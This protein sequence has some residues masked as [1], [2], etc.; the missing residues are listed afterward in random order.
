MT[1]KNVTRNALFTSIISLLLC[2]SMLVGTTFAWFTDSVVSGVNTIAAGNLDVELYHSDKN[3]SGYV[4]A[5]T[6]LFNDVEKWEPG[7]VVF[8]NFKVENVGNLALK[9]NLSI[10]FEN[11]TKVVDA[12]G[13]EHGLSE[14][15][16]V[17]VVEGGFTGGR[18]EAQNIVFDKSLATFALT[19][20]LEGD[21][22][23]EI[24]GIVIYWAPNSNDV[25]NVFNMNN[26]NKGKVLSID[27]GVSLVATQE[28]Y[29]EDSFG[30]DYDEGLILPELGENI[31]LVEQDGIQYY[32]DENGAYVLYLVTENYE[33]DTV[34]IPEGVDA[35]SNYAF[36]YNANV[37]TVNV[38]STV[39][40]LGRAFDTSSVEK[41]VIAEGLE[42]I[43]SRA[44][45]STANL[46]EVV[47]PASV[48]VIEDNAFQKSGIKNIVIPA[49]V[50]TI[51]ETAF[52]AS[53]IET[54]TF[55]G[56][57]SV[58]GFAFRG[59]PNLRTVT[60]KGDNNTFIPSTLNGRNNCW[61]CNGESNNPNTSDIDFYVTNAT[62]AARVKT[63]MGAEAN[64]TD[65]YIIGGET[66]NT[67]VTVKNA[68]ELQTALDNAAGNTVI[69]FTADITGD[70]TA[71]QKEGVN[72]VI[73]G[74]DYK[75]DGT[76]YIDGKAR[77]TGAETLAIKNINFVT[78]K[79]GVDFISSNIAKQYA[80]NVTIEDC[81]FTNNGTGTVVPARFRQAYDI[82]IKDC[83]VDGTFSPLWTTGV[84]GL[85]IQN[86]TANC[87]NEGMTIGASNNVLIEKCNITVPG[88]ESFGIRTDATDG[89]TLTVNN[90]KLNVVT[91]IVIRGSV[92][93]YTVIVDGAHY[94]ATAN[95]LY[96]AV[97]GGATTVMLAAGE[98]DMPD[99]T[100]GSVN[101]VK[102][103]GVGADTVIKLYNASN[104]GDFCL[105]NSTA[106]F[107]N[108][109]IVT[110]IKDWAGFQN[111]KNL[112]FNKCEFENNL[113]L[114]GNATFNE[115]HFV[116]TTNHYNVWAYSANSRNYTAEFNTCVFDCAGKSIYVDGNAG[117]TTT[118]KFTGCTFNDNDGG[119]TDK[120]AIETGTT[121]G[122][123]ATYNIE[124]AD[125]EFNGF[126]IN[127]NGANTNSTIWANKNSMTADKLNITI[128]GVEVY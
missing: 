65:V 126:A 10:N 123:G 56:N 100:A 72:I 76:I 41:V 25:D 46:Q 40:D 108:V 93:T 66:Q 29:E 38:P 80:H 77:F 111:A 128:D 104:G 97:N 89:Y 44:F 69:S 90:C 67:F 55:E 120:A 39:R 127:P 125:C 122:A 99:F 45:R 112:T 62:V 106:T 119:A 102:F 105:A 11:E 58:Q 57:T 78:D 49:T 4:N 94:V 95:Q 47:I 98:Y 43:S 87:E 15:L 117:G 12:E 75:Y 74:A 20:E 118:M 70:V 61:F 63:A 54:V 60:L 88:A 28:M 82:T 3:D 36:A 64:N 6:K 26:S 68:T 51:G 13:V 52:G 114:S 92:D 48:K 27:L 50:E 17:G 32:Y 79:D 30:E 113:F 19:G 85:T 86:V 103:V 91:P 21:T 33:G 73:D 34:N 2:V 37:K 116:V 1:R 24:F 18:A 115:C 124:I 81:T 35:I 71:S 101:G 84:Q 22:T 59:C 5:E 121:Y 107:E 110:E 16:K 96:A 9:Y 31:T 7:V 23:S 83:T 14:V 53:K 42:V 8:E 109:K